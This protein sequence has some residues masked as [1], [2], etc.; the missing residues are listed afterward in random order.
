MTA[1]TEHRQRAHRVRLEWGVEGAA[2][3]AAECAAVVVIDVLSFCT[4]VDVVVGQ[5][6]S[7][8]PQRRSD[9]A[10]AATAGAV[11]AGDRYGTGPSLRPSSLVGLAAGT[12][13]ALAS[14]NGAT[15]CAA[16]GPGVELFAGCLRN[17][18]AVAAALRGVDGPVGLVPAGERWPDATMRVAVEDALGAGAIAAALE[19]RSPE[20]DAAVD[21]FVAA[22]ARGLRGV[23]GR[24]A[25]G[26][27]LV[28][29]G[30]GADVDLAADLD[31]SG[32][33]PRRTD[34]GFLA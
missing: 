5:G 25:S 28:A 12:R 13:L 29:D 16:V 27:E 23:L 34:D 26:L 19:D 15:L 2:L 9:P 8:L 21:L 17:A 22:R 14:P 3:L 30:F 1:R 11:T 18:S 6:A 33:A 24:L 20:A 32:A 10:A 4:S 7:V 31:R